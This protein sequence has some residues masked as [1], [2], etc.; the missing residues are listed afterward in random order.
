MDCYKDE[1]INKIASVII[2]TNNE[3]T[4]ND[5]FYNS[6]KS[7]GRYVSAFRK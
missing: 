7:G 5:V 4:N 6:L 3:Y 1:I 2:I